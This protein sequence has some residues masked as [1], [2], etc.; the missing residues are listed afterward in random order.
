MH[1]RRFYLDR[2]AGD[3]DSQ[4][5]S[6]CLSRSHQNLPAVSS[7]VPENNMRDIGV[8]ASFYS[9]PAGGGAGAVG[10][11]QYYHHHTEEECGG[12]APSSLD[13]HTRPLTRSGSRASFFPRDATTNTVSTT[14]DI[15]SCDGG[16]LAAGV[17][18]AV[19]TDTPPGLVDDEEDEYSPSIQHEHEF[20]T[21]DLDEP[22]AATA[23]AE[24]Q[25]RKEFSLETLR[26]TTPV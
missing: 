8:S 4:E 11:H 24:E 19:G 1:Q 7:C 3:E 20:V 25:R 16:D 5:V 6:P 17:A 2:G 9:F 22:G 14:A 18:V 12:G 15:N 21:F 23:T 26:R 13:L 10:Y